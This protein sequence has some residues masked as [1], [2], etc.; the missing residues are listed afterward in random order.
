VQVVVTIEGVPV[1]FSIL[2][3]SLSDIEGMANLPLALPAG[4]DVA[5]DAAYTY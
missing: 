2:P 3:G 4:A 5:A 1:E